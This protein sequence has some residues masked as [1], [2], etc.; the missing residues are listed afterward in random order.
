MKPGPLIVVSGPSGSGK[1]T[2]IG[3]ALVEFGPRLHHSISS[4]TREPRE[5]E[6]DGVDYHYVSRDQFEAG[7]ANGEFLEFATVFGRDY[8]GTPRTEVEPFRRRGAGGILD[9]DVQGA[10]QIRHTCPDAFTVFVLT[11]PGAYERRLLARGTE[12][13]ESI[14]RRLETARAEVDRA[15]E[16]DYRL[17]NDDVDRAA[18]ELCD[19]IGRLFEG[20]LNG[21]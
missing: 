2:L 1:S 11:P 12:T 19:L 17:L 5:G 13:G 14:E 6:R 7:I 8:Y 21:R 15:H 18:G 9:I 4:T 10:E 16:F 3:R 20:Q